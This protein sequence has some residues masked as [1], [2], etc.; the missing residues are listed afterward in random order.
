MG[1]QNW[2]IDD[3]TRK[4]EEL[5]TKAF[6]PRLWP[7]AQQLKSFIFRKG[8]YKTAPLDGILTETFG[9]DRLFGGK[10]EEARYQRKVAVV[11]TYGTGSEAV[12]LTNYNRAQRNSEPGQFTTITP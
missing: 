12:I 10:C 9:E 5:C 4:F 8:K 2:S 1:V 6:I 11:S 3:C 7:V